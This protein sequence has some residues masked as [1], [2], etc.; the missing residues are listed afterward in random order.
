MSQEEARRRVE[1]IE[2][3]HATELAR[4]E[5]RNRELRSS[6]LEST[7]E[8]T[9]RLREVADLSSRQF[10]LEKVRHGQRGEFLCSGFILKAEGGIITA[11]E[12]E[13]F[14]CICFC[15]LWR[16]GT[17]EG[18]ALLSMAEKKGRYPPKEHTHTR[19]YGTP[20]L[21]EMRIRAQNQGC[22]VQC[23]HCPYSP[24][25]SRCPDNVH[26]ELV[27]WSFRLSCLQ[28]PKHKSNTDVNSFHL[29][30]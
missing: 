13:R 27:V 8:N 5:E 12:A 26:M 18:A 29:R 10:T 16:A 25:Y 4:L 14:S 7:Y 3:K 19:S 6:L 11:S 23:D 28:L 1:A 20:W 24:T 22:S 2:D 30:S 17:Y 9:K 21:L 15:G